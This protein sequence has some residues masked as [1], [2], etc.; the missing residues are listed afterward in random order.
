VDR[1]GHGTRAE[2][3]P[4]LLEYLA[5]RQ[6]PLEMCPLSNVATGVVASLAEHP[7]RRYVARGLAVTINTDDPK[8]FGNSLPR[9]C[10]FS[11]RLV[12]CL[13]RTFGRLF[14]AVSRCPGYLPSVNRPCV[15]LS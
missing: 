2:E 11:A 1:I 9:N 12:I 3:D 8:M 4:A 5:A 13:A 6:M 10:A 14:Y 7:V 15:T